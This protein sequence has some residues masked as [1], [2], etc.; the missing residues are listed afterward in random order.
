MKLLRRLLNKKKGRNSTLLP[1]TLIPSY[2]FL[3]PSYFF[4]L[5]FLFLSGCGREEEAAKDAPHPA[6]PESYMQDEKFIGRLAER[7]TEHRKQVR[8]R[9]AIAERMKA[10]IDAKR[11]ELKTDDVD[12]IK[13]A[14]EKDPA[15]NELC[16]KIEEANAKAEQ[17]RKGTLGV[18][19]ERL[20]KE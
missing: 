13:A 5:T 6:S 14:L 11:D 4:L 12:A 16:K 3:I 20:S 17:A 8:E 10:M 2:L 15:W 18:V 1:S 7:K 19:R 9:N